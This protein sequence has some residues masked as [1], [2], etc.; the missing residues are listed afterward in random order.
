M[1][2]WMENN[3]QTRCELLVLRVCTMFEDCFIPVSR[4]DHLKNS[5]LEL[6]ILN[7]Y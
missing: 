6:L 3:V 2:F 5:P 7:P 1:P 4:E